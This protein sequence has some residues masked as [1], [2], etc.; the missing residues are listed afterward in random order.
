[1]TPAVYQNEMVAAVKLVCC[2]PAC[3][4]QAMRYEDDDT[5]AGQGD[6]CPDGYA[7]QQR[8]VVKHLHIE[9]F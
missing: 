2:C 3:F 5:R 8:I 4:S 7:L 9:A 1:M 6:A